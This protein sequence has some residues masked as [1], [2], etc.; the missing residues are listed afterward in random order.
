MTA[1]R[2]TSNIKSIKNPN[3]NGHVVH[4]HILSRNFKRSSSCTSYISFTF[5]AE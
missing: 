1:E 5:F 3:L 4:W 2:T